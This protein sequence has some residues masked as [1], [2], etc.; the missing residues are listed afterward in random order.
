MIQP[1]EFLYKQQQRFLPDSNEVQFRADNSG[2]GISRCFLRWFSCTSYCGIQVYGHINRR[3]CANC[4][5]CLMKNPDA[6][7]VSHK[8]HGML[9]NASRSE[10]KQ[11]ERPRPCLSRSLSTHAEE[12]S[13][14]HQ[15]PHATVSSTR[16]SGGRLTY[17]D[18]THLIGRWTALYFLCGYR[19]TG[20]R[21]PSD[22]PLP[23]ARHHGVSPPHVQRRLRTDTGSVLDVRDRSC[24]HSPLSPGP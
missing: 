13:L 17:F 8:R 11:H 16:S 1:N 19:G 12:D 10:E 23:T 9:D 24:G 14:K 7:T 4:G 2:N 15:R 3:S 6:T 20:F 21:Q 22:R 18:S 5:W